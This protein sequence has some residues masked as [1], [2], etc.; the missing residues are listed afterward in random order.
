MKTTTY[1]LLIL[2]LSSLASCSSKP[3]RPKLYPSQKNAQSDPLMTQSDIDNCL[4]N[5]QEY[6][7]TEEGQSLKMSLA[8]RGSFRTSVGFGFGSGRSGSGIGTGYSRGDF[9]R[10]PW[11][12]LSSDEKVVRIFTNECLSEKGYKVLGWGQ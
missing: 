10:G 5:A 4:A 11:S 6:L 8:Q 2:I 12:R 3:S 7:K 1:I 9:D